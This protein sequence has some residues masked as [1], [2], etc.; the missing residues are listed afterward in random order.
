M[1]WKNKTC[2]VS[3]GAGF[4]GSHLVS[5]L[6]NKGSKVIII[7]TDDSNFKNNDRLKIIKADVNDID[8]LK[9]D[10]PI[11]YIF[12]LAAL[13]FPKS[14]NENPAQ[15]YNSNVVGT[16]RMLSFALSKKVKK[17]IFTS[18]AQLYGR[19]P[20]YLPVDEKHPIEYLNNFYSL[21]KKQ[22]EDLCVSF[23]E[24]NGLP[25][26]FFRLF[27]TFGPNQKEEYL[28]PT[29][30]KQALTM[31]TI[32]LW[33]EKPTRDFTYVTDTVNAL[34]KGA[35]SGFC[36]GPV[37]I[38]SGNE[39]NIGQIARHIASV[40][41]ADLKFMNKEVIG[42]MRLCCDFT[43]ANR[44]LDWQ[45]NVDFKDGLNRTINYY[46]RLFSDNSSPK[47]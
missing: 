16:F 38:G 29:I 42:S 36:G 44:L 1:V 8:K 9:I 5:E 31:R 43:Y 23:Y 24:R 22:G 19:Y 4:I 25:I 33:N 21:T 32:E 37:N 11:D 12:H 35:E 45:P 26:I 14:C 28:I 41:N 27:N 17:F 46:K 15:A 39:T 34:I 3:G 30:I 13:A 18:T 47:T 10:T 40:L 6:L 20:K 7:D 2:I